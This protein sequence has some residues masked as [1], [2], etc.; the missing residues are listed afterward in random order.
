MFIL[1]ICVFVVLCMVMVSGMRSC[2][3]CR[4]YGGFSVL[5]VG[6]GIFC[7]FVFVDVFV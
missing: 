6:C 1:Y 4:V 7:E 3:L 5:G 2:G